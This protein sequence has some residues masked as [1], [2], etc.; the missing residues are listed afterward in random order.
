MALLILLFFVVF[1]V[2]DW[3][4]FP[5]P[6]IWGFFILGGGLIYWAIKSN[7]S[8]LKIVL[9]NIAILFVCLGFLETVVTVMLA[10]QAAHE[11]K[12]G[13]Y[14]EKYFRADEVLGY[15]PRNNVRASVREYHDKELIYNVKGF[16][17]LR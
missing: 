10:T 3:E 8:A 17:C 4:Y 1:P 15:A 5:H 12:E 13:D 2:V 7:S 11:R 9:F 16:A 6:F 14:N